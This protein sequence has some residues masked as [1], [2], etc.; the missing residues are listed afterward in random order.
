MVPSGRGERE[1]WA[2]RPAVTVGNPSIM[3]TKITPEFDDST[4][5][6][7]HYEPIGSTAGRSVDHTRMRLDY[8][9]MTYPGFTVG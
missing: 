7:N 5:R 4:A 1:R 8:T 6:R 3:R 2:S 9:N